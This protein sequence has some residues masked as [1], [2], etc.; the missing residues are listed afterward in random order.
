M[1]K[2]PAGVQGERSEDRKNGVG[3]IPRCVAELAC[4]QLRVV[5]DENAFLLE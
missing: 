2:G 5:A 1:G 4:V 3:K